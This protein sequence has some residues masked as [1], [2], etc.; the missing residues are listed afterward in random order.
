MLLIEGFEPSTFRLGAWFTFAYLT[1]LCT[2][3]GSRCF[4]GSNDQ[5]APHRQPD[6]ATPRQPRLCSYRLQLV[7]QSCKPQ[8]LYYS[9]LLLAHAYQIAFAH[10]AFSSLYRSDDERFNNIRIN[11]R[12]NLKHLTNFYLCGWFLV[13]SLKFQD[14]DWLSY[15]IPDLVEQFLQPFLLI[16]WS[17]V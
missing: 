15:F 12:R 8:L 6:P 11:F 1:N 13:K 10:L 5:L 7:Q 16:L 2:T 9:V 14:G 4:R 17:P 3:T